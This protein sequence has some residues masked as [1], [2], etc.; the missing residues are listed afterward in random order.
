MIMVR[1]TDRAFRRGAV[2][3]F[4]FGLTCLLTAGLVN[5]TPPVTLAVPSPPA[6]ESPAPA[7]K[8]S[9]LTA[10][11]PDLVVHEWGTFLGMSGSDGTSLEGMYHEEHALP[12]FVHARGRDQLQIPVSLL[13]GETPVIYFY[14][15]RRQLVRIGVRF[16]QGVWT[17]WYPQAARV[18][19]SLVAQAESPDR[20]GPG[21][22]CWNAEILPAAVVESQKR[23]QNNDSTAL[24]TTS[25]D[26][27]W[28]Y[29][30]DVDAAYVRCTNRSASA[31]ELERFLF[32]RGLG[33]AHLPLRF[34]A[35]R[36]G[37]LSVERSDSVRDG[38]RHLFV[39]HVQNGRGAFRYLSEIRPGQ[40]IAGVIPGT[41]EMR[42]LPEFTQAVAHDLASR[43]EASGLYAREAQAMV[44]TWTASYFQTEGTRGLCVL[45]QGWTD[46]FIPMTVV[47]RPK[48]VVRVM[49]G[50]VELLDPERERLAEAAVRMLGAPDADRRLQAFETLKNEG[51][52]VEPI[53]R[54]VER[55]SSDETVRVLCRRLLRTG[56]V[57]DLRSALHS[58]ADGKAL[59]VDSRLLRAHLGRLL[60]EM[61][62]E[63]E[64]RSEGAAI[65]SMLERTSQEASGPVNRYQ[66]M[67]L[68]TI[69]GAAL[70]AGGIDRS[71]A[72]VYGSCIEDEVSN[73]QSFDA[74][75]VAWY[76][77][78]WVGR[79]YG[80]SLVR[81]GE[82]ERTLAESP[83]GPGLP[84]RRSGKFA[85][86]DH[87]AEARIPS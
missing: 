77:E 45:P 19:P 7:P 78:W 65:L 57:T 9:P 20:L 35:K 8:P 47:P 29:A 59:N 25:A 17:H 55:T 61:G 43:L 11:T 75:T 27:L 46:T 53:L 71:A 64:A 42:P 56:F 15:G 5:L 58:A 67:Y 34:E 13:K 49:V 31:P 81:S 54:R 40:T 84:A 26:A 69:R 83:V 50:R 4:G 16:P 68:K 70:E 32:Y 37:T 52:Y 41:H 1:R 51:R 66:Q 79:G 63:K 39:L 72:R 48:Q 6:E 74:A 30:R 22:I 23:T 82:S 24:P 18:E 76:R 60:R 87:P 38:I 44:N 62:L 80:R 86:P 36:G 2:G 14:T 21:N 10:E 73:R 33:R 12:A 85:G 28:R 3:L